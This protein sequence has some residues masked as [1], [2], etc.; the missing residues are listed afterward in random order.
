[1]LVKIPTGGKSLR[2]FIIGIL[3]LAV[4]FS[5][6]NYIQGYCIKGPFGECNENYNIVVGFLNGLFSILGWLIGGIILALI[7]IR[8]KE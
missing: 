2:I 7:F 4:F 6:A 5:V 8:D 1:M 3:I